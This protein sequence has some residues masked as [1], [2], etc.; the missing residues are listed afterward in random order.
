M[1]K[2]EGGTPKREEEEEDPAVVRIRLM[3]LTDGNTIAGEL[4]TRLALLEAGQWTSQLQREVQE[5][6]GSAQENI[7]PGN[8]R[9]GLAD[10]AF[11][12]RVRGAVLLSSQHIRAGYHGRIDIEQ[13]RM[14]RMHRS[15]MMRIVHIYADYSAN[16]Y[17]PMPRHR[18]TLNQAIEVRSALIDLT[19]VQREGSKQQFRPAFVE[20]PEVLPVVTPP[21]GPVAIA[22]ITRQEVI[23]AMLNGLMVA[24]WAGSPQNV[25]PRFW[26]FVD[27]YGSKEQQTFATRVKEMILFA[28]KE[29]YTIPE[30]EEEEEGP[31][32]PPG[33]LS[34]AAI[35]E[36]R[37]LR[38]VV[39]RKKREMRRRYLRQ[40]RGRGG[41][42]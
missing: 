26:V 13:R 19:V 29:G 16:Q 8:L 24:T 12:M 33:P 15:L 1:D 42:Q 14:V 4:A 34:E 31:S 3:N 7:P 38:R 41:G 25:N 36:E 40:Q 32:E 2:P 18:T 23:N 21:S 10:Q 6:W 5:L 30:E 22:M 27:K 11:G 39:L 17:K 28:E 20:P 9:N 35:A 37:M